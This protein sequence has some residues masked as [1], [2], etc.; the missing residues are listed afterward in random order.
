MVS[1]FRFELAL[2]I[3]GLCVIDLGAKAG[4]VDLRY[5]ASVKHGIEISAGVAL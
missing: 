1:T 5:V 3:R 4:S 2:D